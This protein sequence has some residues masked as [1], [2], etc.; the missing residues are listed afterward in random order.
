[1]RSQLLYLNYLSR[2]NQQ[3]KL[4]RYT[5]S[6]QQQEYSSSSRNCFPSIAALKIAR[7]VL[8]PGIYINATAILQENV[9][10]A[11]NRSTVKRHIQ[12]RGL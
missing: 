4:F 9:K 6:K 8:H 5:Q 7:T 10:D 1:M 11:K 12:A 3:T 2:K